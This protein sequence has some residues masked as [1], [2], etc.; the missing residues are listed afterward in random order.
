MKTLPIESSAAL[1]LEPQIKSHEE[2]EHNQSV[3]PHSVLY[4]KNHR[5]FSQTKQFIYSVLP[6]Q[7]FP[8]QSSILANPMMAHWAETC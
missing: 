2:E 6:Q 3:H 7:Y 1:L 5:R 4:N 8:A